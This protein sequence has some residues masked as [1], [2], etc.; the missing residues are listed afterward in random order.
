MEEHAP[1]STKYYNN[2]FF[3]LIAKDLSKGAEITLIL[4]FLTRRRVLR[5]N[6]RTLSNRENLQKYLK[7]DSGCTGWQSTPQKLLNINL[8]N[9]GG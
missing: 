5:K 7:F 1:K 3:L 6:Q 2:K 8:P 9:F 4:I